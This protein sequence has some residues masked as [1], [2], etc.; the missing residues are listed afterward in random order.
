MSAQPGIVDKALH[1]IADQVPV[2]EVAKDV[3]AAVYFFASSAAVKVKRTPT[4][5]SISTTN[6]HFYLSTP[7][8][9][10]G[11][12]K[13]SRGG[14][15]RPVHYA[16]HSHPTPVHATFGEVER[17]L[18]KKPSRASVTFGQSEKASRLKKL[19]EE[20]PTMTNARKDWF[21]WLF[22]SPKGEKW[23]EHN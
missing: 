5:L 21:R 23:R 17:R 22:Q 2:V 15:A 14:K 13:G 3:A 12:F 7:V 19:K 1:P 4:A 20:E 9:D 16:S 10:G 8:G 6:A 18:S 11:I